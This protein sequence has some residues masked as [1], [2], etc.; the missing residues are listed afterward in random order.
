[1]KLRHRVERALLQAILA[2]PEASLR[3]ALG[4]RVLSP[5]GLVLDVE[6]QL[7]VRLADWY[8]YRELRE[9]GVAAAR[10]QMDG[11][12]DLVDFRG[13]ASRVET[14]S[15]DT[16]AG[17]L[18]VR[19]YRPRSKRTPRPALV[20]FHG[21][22]WV[23]GSAASHDGL[24][25]FLARETDAIVVSVDYRLAP[26]HRFPAAVD[27]AV[28]ATRWVIANAASLGAD[29]QAVGVG[30]DSAGGNLAAVVAHETQRDPIR[31]IVQFLVYPATDL[32]RSLPS[33]RLFARGYML[34]RESMDFYLENYVEEASRTS[35]R[36]S[37][38]F[39]PE[40]SFRG[41][42]PAIV[43]TA[44]FDPLR[45]E[46]RAYAETMRRAGVRLDYRCAE[47]SIHGFFSFGG[48]F[49]RARHVIEESARALG[50][51][52]KRA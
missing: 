40:A 28:A 9:L 44:G 11:G 39:A 49:P 7:L 38:L 47:G 27:D 13:V 1:M 5:D 51:A 21:G 14:R 37:P 16:E 22:G 17:P 25:R 32:T 41:L 18:S 45:D 30:G 20:Y 23:V 43:V 46:G 33:H 12:V 10:A 48:V 6:A 4:P 26:E 2:L 50:H 31:P 8:G 19:I 29:P 3:L 24:A 34:T 36:A 35:P 15:I 52:L 42:P